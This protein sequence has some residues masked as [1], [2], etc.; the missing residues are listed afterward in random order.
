M[1]QKSTQEFISDEDTGLLYDITGSQV[2]NP[3]TKME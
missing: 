2:E 1:I 3:V